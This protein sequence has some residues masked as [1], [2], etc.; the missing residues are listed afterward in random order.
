MTGLVEVELQF[1]DAFL[2][3]DELGLVFQELAEGGVITE[4]RPLSIDVVIS[5]RAGQRA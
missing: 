2:F 4:I 3:S 5:F 1:L